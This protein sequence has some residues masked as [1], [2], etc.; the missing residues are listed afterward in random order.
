MSIRELDLRLNHKLLAMTVLALLL[1]SSVGYLAYREL[2]AVER[3]YVE[4]TRGTMPLLQAIEDLRLAA[5]AIVGSTSEYGFITALAGAD[6]ATPERQEQASRQE[7]GEADEIA[8]ARQRLE[9]ALA[10]YGALAGRLAPDELALRD[11]LRAESDTL[12]ATSDE[13]RR[14]LEQPGAGSALLPAKERLEAAEQTL[15]ASLDGA[16]EAQQREL[17]RRTERVEATIADGATA[18]LLLTP[19]LLLLATA[20]S[21]A[22]AGS[23]TAPL[24]RLTAAMARVVAGE[25][26]DLPEPRTRD[27]IGILLGSFRTMAATLRRLG[28]ENARILAAL[29]ASEARFRDIAETASDWLWEAAPDLRLTYLSARFAVVTGL[30]CEQ[31]LGTQL[32]HFLLPEAAA[33]DAPE[34]FGAVIAARRPFRDLRCGYRDADGQVRIC[35]LAGSAIVAPDGRFHGYRG[36]ATD[37]TAETRAQARAQHLSLHDPLTGLP[38]RALLVARLAEAL[39][40]ARHADG[41]TAVLCLDLDRFKEVNDSHGHAAGDL[42]LQETAHRLLACVRE[43]DT[44]ARL[45]GDEFIVVQR[46]LKTA[47][48]A[49]ALGQRLLRSFADPV[50]LDGCKALVG[51]SIGIALAPADGTSAEQ[52]LRN[53]DIALYR[54]KEEGRGTYRFF[55]PAMD[56]RLQARRALEHDLRQA[57]ARD[58]LELHYQPKIATADGRLLGAEALVRWRHPERGLTLPGAFIPIA[59]E[60]GLIVPIGAW[61]LRTACAQAARWP[62]G[63][64]AVNLSPVQFRHG[65]LVELV[66]AALRASGLE[67]HRLELEITESVLLQDV[68]DMLA[69]LHGL[70][71]L[72]VQLAMDDFG[73]GY[74]SLNYLQRFPFDKLKIDQSFVQRLEDHPS[75]RTIVGAVLGLGRALGLETNAEGVETAAQLAFLRAAGCDEVQ[76]YYFS[77]A[78]PAAELEPLITRPAKG[79]LPRGSSEPAAACG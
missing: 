45:G 23:I 56:A 29:Q 39:D 6:R 3:A 26:P 1:G 49:Q 4:V 34:A 59:E 30:P 64:I 31:V 48:D 16:I 12:L 11:T 15:L 46:G 52:L 32:D 5:R 69:L 17:A 24:R 47:S 63:S 57:L 19:P 35:R 74:S 55:E 72:G 40:S 71:A 2:R 75:A 9:E 70:K 65:D 38:N 62:E 79:P 61:V 58:E 53:A 73:T 43:T 36:A 10:R 76:G 77:R 68:P 8:T 18:L 54:A 22:L 21:Q 50:P 60:T 66:A 41:L 25:V 67:P 7:D 28:D 33:L 37:I 51:L 27:E 13:L 42:L 78:V 44:V 20:G 14:L